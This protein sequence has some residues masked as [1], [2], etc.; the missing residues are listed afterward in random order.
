[1]KAIESTVVRVERKID[2]SG[3]REQEL[4]AQLAA[5][6]EQLEEARDALRAIRA[7]EV[8]ALVHQGGVFKLDSASDENDRFHAQ[9]LKDINEAVV[10][11]DT[12]QR[13]TFINSAAEEQYGVKASE[14]L[15][16]SIDELYAQEW[17][18]PSDPAAVQKALEEEG[19]W[20]GECV[21]IRRDGSAM[22]V[23]K[24]LSR[25][26]DSE[27]RPIGMLAVVRDVSPRARAQ[28]ALAEAARQKD[29][30]LATLA[31][32]LRNPLS[33][34]MNGLYL[35][36]VVKE[37]PVRLQETQDMMM[38]QLRHMV[39]LVDDL[40]DLS[41][42]SRGKLT[43]KTEMLDLRDILPLALE[44]SKPLIDEYGH[45]L[46]HHVPADPVIVRGDPNRLM[47]VVSNLLNNA[48]K[49]TAPQGTIELWLGS[50]D[51]HA[52]IKVKDNGIG[53]AKEHLQR[54]FD[55]FAQ[56]RQGAFE[57]KGGGLGIGLN[58]ANKLVTMH[59]GSIS[60]HSDGP[61]RGSEFIVT[62]PL[63]MKLSPGQSGAHGM[64]HHQPEAQR[65][66]VVDDNVDAATS[67]ALLLRS[68]GHDV[69]VAH[70]GAQALDIGER[71]QPGTVLMDIGM[72]V[73]DGITSCERMRETEWGA[74]IVIVAIS[75]WGQEQDRKR[76]AKAGFDQH[77]VKP[78]DRQT[79]DRLLVGIGV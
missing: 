23:E 5:L 44:A 29:H 12:A 77:L 73:M 48:A 37:D 24:T 39:R 6:R 28:A 55:M 18:H 17:L 49:Y 20:R 26:H 72:P 51:G 43:L 47:Q 1:M 4:K 76:S 59:N 16:R 41:R 53:I 62:L 34:L 2:E 30:F 8:D 65:I 75:G 52:V 40:M 32:E 11:M 31:H 64:P 36:D 27:G 61:G 74:D 7:G 68:A 71:F 14:V 56:V 46:Q 45:H 58:I 54:V 42:I 3:S 33:P 57:H 22:Q 35:L 9:V 10:A 63:S 15:G 79:L 50:M 38:R 78:V 13:I 19:Q 70:N 67:L 66:L 25:S 21:H 60:V 69:R